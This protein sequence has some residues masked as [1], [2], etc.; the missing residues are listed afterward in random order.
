MTCTVKGATKVWC[1]GIITIVECDNCGARYHLR[2]NNTLN[3][4][5][6]HR[7]CDDCYLPMETVNPFYK[8]SRSNNDE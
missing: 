2:P 8:D 3:I 1:R 7:V 4:P 5:K 6:L